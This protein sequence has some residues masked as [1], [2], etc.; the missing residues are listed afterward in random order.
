MKTRFASR[1]PKSGGFAAGEMLIKEGEPRAS[2]FSCSGEKSALARNN[3]LSFA[4]GPVHFS[5]RSRS[6]WAR[7]TCCPRAPSRDSR[8]I[9][10][11]EQEIL[12]IVAALPGDCTEIFRAVL[13]RLRNIEGSARNSREKLGGARNDVRRPGA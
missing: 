1:G 13:T 8:L 3:T 7:L 11:P 12:E 10:F 6:Y 2:E 4:T 5:A 9:V